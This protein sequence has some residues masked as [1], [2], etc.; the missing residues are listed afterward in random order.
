VFCSPANRSWRVGRPIAFF[1][2]AGPLAD[3]THCRID[4]QSLALARRPLRLDLY[5]AVFAGQVASKAAPRPIFRPGD[6]SSFYWIPVPGG[7]F[8]RVLCE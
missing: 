5:P 2:K 7:P 1:A 3:T 6:Q 8:I 4:S